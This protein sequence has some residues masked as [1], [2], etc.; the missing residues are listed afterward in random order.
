MSAHAYGS[1]TL[2][3]TPRRTDV[4]DPSPVAAAAT[5]RPD[6][7]R[8]VSWWRTALL[9]MVLPLSTCTGP[10]ADPAAE[11]TGPSSVASTA[12]AAAPTTTSP[13][14]AEPRRRGGARII[15][16][17]SEFGP[18]LY[19]ATG[20]AIYLFDLEAS[21]QPRCYDACSVAWPPVLTQGDPVAGR[22]VRPRLLGTV[23]RDDGTV[24]AT[25]AGHPLYFYAHEGP[26]RVLCHDFTDF[27]GTWFVVQP[28]GRAAP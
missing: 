12:T 21:P 15:A 10:A 20:H 23:E 18:M 24:Q 28:G 6:Q 9:V 5:A 19:S 11:P 27:G 16:A 7:N 8:R 1:L 13:E 26:W 17:D 2:R 14:P 25:Y 3:R 4:I 22:S